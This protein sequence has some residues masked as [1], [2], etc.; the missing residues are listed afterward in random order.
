LASVNVSGSTV[1]FNLQHLTLEDLAAVLDIDSSFLAKIERG[2]RGMN[3]KLLIKLAKA[4]KL[5]YTDI[6][7]D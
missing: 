4:L 7:R 5:E 2:E 3:I 6:L 1:I